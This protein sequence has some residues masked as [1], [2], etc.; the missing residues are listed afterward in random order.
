MWKSYN[1]TSSGTDP[2]W[3]QTLWIHRKHPSRQRAPAVWQERCQDPGRA[4]A[5]LIPPP[6]LCQLS[7]LAEAPQGCTMMRGGG[8]PRRSWESFPRHEPAAGSWCGPQ[9]MAAGVSARAAEHWRLQSLNKL[10]IRLNFLPQFHKLRFLRLQACSVP[11]AALAQG[12]PLSL[13]DE[14]ASLEVPSGSSSAASQA[15]QASRQGV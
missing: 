3:F 5:Q 2:S 6:G 4:G 12:M 1:F 7:H 14:P 10:E 8:T 13:S 9:S 11:G 15:T